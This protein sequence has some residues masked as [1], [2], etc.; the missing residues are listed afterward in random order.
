MRIKFNTPETTNN[1]KLIKVRERCETNMV[2]YTIKTFEH[3]N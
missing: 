2:F 3:D 1:L